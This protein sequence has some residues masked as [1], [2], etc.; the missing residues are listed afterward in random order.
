MK[1]KAAEEVEGRLNEKEIEL[2]RLHERMAL[3]LQER[4]SET[5]NGW[6]SA[7]QEKEVLRMERE[8]E[9]LGLSYE[10]LR[11]EADEEFARELAEEEERGGGGGGWGHGGGG[12]IPGQGAGGFRIL[13]WPGI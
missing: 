10:K 5:G 8:I 3:Q 11:T 7:E 1:Y 12:G 2:A 9:E 4:G 13:N 6:P